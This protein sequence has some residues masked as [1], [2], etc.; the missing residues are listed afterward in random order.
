MNSFKK[1]VTA[2]LTGQTG[3]GKSS[4][5][6]L[7]AEN[8]CEIIDTDKIARAI[9]EK[10]SP[11]LSLLAEAFG[12][13]IIEEGVLNRK[14]LAKRAFSSRENTEKL[15]AV[16]HPEITRRVKERIEKAFLEGKKAAVI[17]AAALFESGED[18]LCDFTAAVVCPEEIRL[19]RIIERDSLTAEQAKTRIKA[20]YGEEYY[21]GKADL[22][23]R[24]YPPYSL[25][26]ETEKILREIRRVSDEK[27][28]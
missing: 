22:I 8:G 12:E 26:E 15:N 13:D 7:L 25:Y 17:D 24:N 28:L 21:T 10:G 14:L 20:Q 4:V 5:G 18:K 9:T 3:A 27:K 16:T 2:G 19:K 11:V 1:G 6:K 23:I